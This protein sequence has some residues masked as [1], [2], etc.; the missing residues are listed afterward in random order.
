[1]RLIME[2]LSPYLV[3]V[4]K[5]PRNAKYTK[6]YVFN[7]KGDCSDFIYD[8][9][10]ELVRSHLNWRNVGQ[11]TYIWSTDSVKLEEW[12]NKKEWIEKEPEKVEDIPTHMADAFSYVAGTFPPLFNMEGTLTGRF[13][14]KEEEMKFSAK[15]ILDIKV[16]GKTFTVQD[17]VDKDEAVKLVSELAKR[18]QVLQ[19]QVDNLDILSNTSNVSVV[20]KD[21]ITSITDFIMYIDENI[22]ED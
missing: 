14:T 12:L 20:L 13:I 10:N 19:D 6:A 4:R 11:Y 21:E 22:K 2:D 9:F 1:M 3:T 8:A 17:P 16:N 18:A 5:T 7:V 15:H